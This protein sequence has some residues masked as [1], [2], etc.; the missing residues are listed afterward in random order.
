MSEQSECVQEVI[1]QSWNMC[2]LPSQDI[3]SKVSCCNQIVEDLACSDALNISLCENLNWEEEIESPEIDLPEEW[4]LEVYNMGVQEMMS[5]GAPENIAKCVMNNL[6]NK[7]TN[8]QNLTRDIFEKTTLK[9]IDGDIKD[10]GSRFDIKQEEEI[11]EEVEEEVEDDDDKSS[12]IVGIVGTV[13]IVLMLIAVVT[14]LVLY[15]GRS[16]M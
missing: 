6:V 4:A 7:Y 12:S 2:N 15:F 1:R 13:A 8:P 9:C 3:T 16:S 5:K 14:M 10:E 11:E